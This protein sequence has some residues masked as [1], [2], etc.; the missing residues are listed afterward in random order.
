[1]ISE[2]SITSREGLLFWIS[3][4]LKCPPDNIN[5]DDSLIELGM[6]SLLMMRLPVMLK[7]AGVSVKLADLRKGAT[8]GNWVHLIKSSKQ[9]FLNDEVKQII[10]DGQSICFEGNNEKYYWGFFS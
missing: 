4:S 1:M 10:P 9:I 3:T 6:N 5:E 7:K 8:L 2:A